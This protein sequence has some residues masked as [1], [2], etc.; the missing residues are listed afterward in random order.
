MAKKKVDFRG[1]RPLAEYFQFIAGPALGRA[2]PGLRLIETIQRGA[3]LHENALFIE[4]RRVRL[5]LAISRSS[6]PQ[7]WIQL[8][9][10][11]ILVVSGGLYDENESIL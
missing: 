3:D 4:K 1:G 11:V 8:E 7:K 5:I 2:R 6:R 10:S 9:I